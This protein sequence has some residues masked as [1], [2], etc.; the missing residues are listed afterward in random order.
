MKSADG[1][2]EIS[3]P[4]DT[5]CKRMSHVPGALVIEWGITANH[6]RE[7]AAG[8]FSRGYQDAIDDVL[9]C[10]DRLL[11][12]AGEPRQKKRRPCNLAVQRPLRGLRTGLHA[13][14]KSIGSRGR[15]R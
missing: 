1:M 6:M 10:F 11:R 7:N 13:R 8:Q 2:G 15:E 5:G 3:G 9:S 12:T 4:D 14:R